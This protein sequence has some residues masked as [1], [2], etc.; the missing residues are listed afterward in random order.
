MRDDDDEGDRSNEADEERDGERGDKTD[1]ENGEV[2]FSSL[3]PEVPRHFCFAGL[4]EEREEME[5]P[6]GI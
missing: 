1:G 2:K 4:P 5:K 6:N 3:R